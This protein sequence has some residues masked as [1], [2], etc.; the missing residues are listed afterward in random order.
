MGTC[1]SQR[2]DKQKKTDA[3]SGIKETPGHTFEVKDEEITANVVEKVEKK[4]VE[5]KVEN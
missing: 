3:K 1:C 5:K 2:D 4:Q